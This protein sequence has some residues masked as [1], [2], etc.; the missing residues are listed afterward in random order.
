MLTT[1]PQRDQ[2]RHPSSGTRAD[3]HRGAARAAGL[4]YLVT[5]VASIPAQFVSYA[6][7]L[8]NPDYVL[9]GGADVRVQW[10]GLLEVVT[11]LACI[12]TA[13]ILFPVLRRY[14]YGAALGFVSVRILEAALI[15]TGVV[16]M[17]SV[18]SLRQPGAAGVEATSRVVAAEALVAVHDWTFLLGP[19]VIPG[20][21]ALLLGYLMYRSGLVPRIIPAVGLVGAPI[22]LIAGTASL[23]GL[24][25]PAS[26]WTVLATLPIFAWELSLGVWL[27]VR[28]FSRTPAA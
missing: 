6:P 13:V 12:A 9:G 27:T 24:N 1:T 16:A 8:D 26:I 2:G 17:L 23:V 15:V 10:G 7:V 14:Q 4:A 21:N 5:I 18:V 19:G 22:F 28:G 20:I 25:E 11:A 3:Q